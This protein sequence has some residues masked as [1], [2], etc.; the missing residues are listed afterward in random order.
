MAEVVILKV[1]VAFSCVDGRVSMLVLNHAPLRLD[2]KAT[3]SIERATRGVGVGV[4][5]SVEVGMLVVVGLDGGV[6]VGEGV[7]TEVGVGIRGEAV[8]H[9]LNI[10]TAVATRIALYIVLEFIAFSFIVCEHCCRTVWLTCHRNCKTP[11]S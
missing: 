7:N 9:A 6:E 10:N 2:W 3:R 4:A 1:A 11:D 5:V 8:P